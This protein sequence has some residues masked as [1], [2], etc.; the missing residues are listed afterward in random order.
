M[1]NEE[2]KPKLTQHS[3]GSLMKI[4]LGAAIGVAISLFAQWIKASADYVTRSE[5][6]A[7]MQE[8]SPYTKDKAYILEALGRNETGH[9]DFVASLNDLKESS[10]K[11]MAQQQVILDRVNSIESR[12]DKAGYRR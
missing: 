12:L 1:S 3:N 8:N 11:V 5:V 2:S 7:M 9:E 10:T 6:T 4:V